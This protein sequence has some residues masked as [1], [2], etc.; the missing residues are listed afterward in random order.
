MVYSSLNVRFT[1]KRKGF[2]F[3]YSFKVSDALGTKQKLGIPEFEEKKVKMG[4]EQTQL[5]SV[6]ESI[7]FKNWKYKNM[8]Y[9]EYREQIYKTKLLIAVKINWM[10]I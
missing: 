8:L 4:G 7:T 5:V 10:E 6:E 3:F 9:L 2:F 1:K